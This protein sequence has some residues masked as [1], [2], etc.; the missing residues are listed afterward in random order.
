[1]K[2]FYR[3]AAFFF[4][5]FILTSCKIFGG[6]TS[7]GEETHFSEAIVCEGKSD[8]EQLAETASNSLEKMNQRTLAESDG[9]RMNL[10]IP[11]REKN[12][13]I[14]AD[15]TT[16]DI[17]HIDCYEYSIFSTN[18]HQREALFEA[19]FDDGKYRIEHNTYMYNDFWEI[20]SC[21]DESTMYTFNIQYDNSGPGITGE[22]IF[23]L[24][25]RKSDLIDFDSNQLQSLKDSTLLPRVENILDRC[26]RLVSAIAPD[27]NYGVDYIR[28]FGTEKHE[29]FLWIVYSQ[30]VDGIPVTAYRDLKFYVDKNGVEYFG[31]AIYKIG[32]SILNK[33]I[34]SVED[35]LKIFEEQIPLYLDEETLSID[36]Y[37]DSQ[38]AITKISLEYLAVV[39]PNGEPK[40]MPIWRFQLGF[41]EASRNLLRDRILAV[42]AVDGT[43][44][45]ERRRNTF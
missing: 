34:I 33:P 32:K 25:N 1:M 22:K 24:L 27:E 40:I 26:Q 2:V 43:I 6:S 18:E 28:P 37:F 44:V 3:V 11:Y 8:T 17:Q 16:F 7:D 10:C 4:L 12:I 35:A 45:S 15:V 39:N 5:L 31:G 38:I 23:N 41:D 13:V 20:I 30:S 21:D 19:F 36:D 9:K 14:N 42:N 29:P